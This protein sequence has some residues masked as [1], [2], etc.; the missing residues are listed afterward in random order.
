M[1]IYVQK[2]S[3]IDLSNKTAAVAGGTTGIGQALAERFSKAGANVFVI[4]RN[5]QRGDNV[6]K[7]LTKLGNGNAKYEFIKADLR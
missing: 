7:E 1:S 6:I 5:Q 4:G 2:N 3:S